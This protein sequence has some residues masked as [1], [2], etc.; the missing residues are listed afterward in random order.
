[1]KILYRN[2]GSDLLNVEKTLLRRIL[3]NTFPWILRNVFKKPVEAWKQFSITLIILF[4]V[5]LGCCTY[6]QNR[7]TI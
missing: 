5:F 1:M 6:H 7:G 3:T 4:L 2:L